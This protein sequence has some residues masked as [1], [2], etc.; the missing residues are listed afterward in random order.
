MLCRRNGVRS[1]VE[2]ATN[3]LSRCLLCFLHV[4]C[5]HARCCCVMG[6]ARLGRVICVLDTFVQSL[7]FGSPGSRLCPQPPH[8]IRGCSA[9]FSATSELHCIRSALNDDLKYLIWR[10]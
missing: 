9:L 5:A 10:S 1:S 6:P 3:G 2:R 7:F 8:P 4:A